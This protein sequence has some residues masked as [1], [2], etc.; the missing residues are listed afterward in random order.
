M[1]WGILSIYLNSNVYDETIKPDALDSKPRE[2][3][4]TNIKEKPTIQNPLI[5]NLTENKFYN[6]DKH[7]GK[8]KHTMRD[9]GGE[10]CYI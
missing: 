9:I 8:L 3:I 5:N 2:I 6:P 7:A 10:N 4:I 1:E